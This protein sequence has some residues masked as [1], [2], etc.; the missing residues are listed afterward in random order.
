MTITSQSQHSE[1][2]TPPSAFPGLKPLS[3]EMPAMVSGQ[4]SAVRPHEDLP[5]PTPLP[6]LTPLPPSVPARAET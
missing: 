1:L 3:Q 5:T 6:E 2:K 4:M